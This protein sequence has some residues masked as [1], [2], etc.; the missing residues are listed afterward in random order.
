MKNVCIVLLVGLC[1]CVAPSMLSPMPADQGA[2]L[3]ALLGEYRN[4][5]VPSTSEIVEFWGLLR[6]QLL[7]T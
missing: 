5:T 1:G 3:H 7:M 2:W 4:D 6:R